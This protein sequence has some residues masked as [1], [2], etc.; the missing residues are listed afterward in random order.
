MTIETDNR[1]SVELDAPVGQLC[2]P[3]ARFPKEQLSTDQVI[4]ERLEDISRDFSKKDIEETVIVMNDG[5]DAA[6]LDLDLGFIER[7]ITNLVLTY[8]LDEVSKVLLMFF[9]K[10]V[11]QLQKV[12]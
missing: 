10:F 7:H 4:L 5:F 9:N 11:L 2:R 6:S 8:G 12:G 3:R 1:F